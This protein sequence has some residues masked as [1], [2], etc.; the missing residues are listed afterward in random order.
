M[1]TGQRYDPLVVDGRYRGFTT[2]HP[3]SATL[4]ACVIRQRH[5]RRPAFDGSSKRA[6]PL[7]LSAWEAKGI[8]GL[9]PT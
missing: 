3:G 5:T 2:S 9:F 8:Y 7:E 1:S 4:L 6:A